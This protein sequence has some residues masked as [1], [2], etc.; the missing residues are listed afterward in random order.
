MPKLDGKRVCPVSRNHNSFGA[1]GGVAAVVVALVV[2]PVVAF[3]VFCAVPEP[4]VDAFDRGLTGL[5]PV[6]V[7]TGGAGFTGASCLV[8]LV[9]WA[10]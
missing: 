8:A 6:S 10:W 5:A 7:L 3:T 2:A 4:S 1:C 9:D